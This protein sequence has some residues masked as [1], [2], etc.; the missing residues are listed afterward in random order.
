MNQLTIS[1]TLFILTLVFVYLSLNAIKVKHGDESEEAKKRA[2]RAHGNFTEYTPFALI[3]LI[4]LALQNIT[5]ILYFILCLALV[6]GRVLHAYGMITLESNETKQMWGRLWGMRFTLTTIL[7][8]GILVFV[9]AILHA[10][11]IA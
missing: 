7:A 5:P 8:C 9:Y 4:V 11:N 2:N 10:V 6:I 3:L 1:I